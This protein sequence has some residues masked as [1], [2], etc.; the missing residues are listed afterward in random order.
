MGQVRSLNSSVPFPIMYHFL[1]LFLLN[2][3]I[4]VLQ[5]QKVMQKPE[6]DLKILTVIIS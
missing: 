2:F 5:H 3:G 6:E 4:L 1:G